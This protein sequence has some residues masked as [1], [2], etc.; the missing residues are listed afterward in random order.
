MRAIALC[1]LA[2]A[3]TGAQAQDLRANYDVQTYRLDLQ[4]NPTTK[5][6]KGT[7]GIEAKALKPTDTLVLDLMAGRTVSAVTAFAAPLTPASAMTGK[8][9]AFT[10]TGDLITIK[11]GR[12]HHET[13]T[14]LTV[15]RATWGEAQQLGRRGPGPAPRPSSA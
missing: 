12:T 9:L 15:P 8:A 14:T 3:T 4:V 7:V 2:L 5:T 10:H 13:T 11:L 1:L 6:L